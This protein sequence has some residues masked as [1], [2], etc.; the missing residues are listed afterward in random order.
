M[1]YFDK[2]KLCLKTVSDIKN[3][4]ILLQDERL[5]LFVKPGKL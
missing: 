2:N 5:E 3:V 1:V 4:R